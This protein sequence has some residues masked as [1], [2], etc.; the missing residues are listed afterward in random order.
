MAKEDALLEITPELLEAARAQAEE[1]KEMDVKRSWFT[2]AMRRVVLEEH[3][4]CKDYGYDSPEGRKDLKVL[5]YDSIGEKI[6]SWTTPEEE[7]M[8]AL[9]TYNYGER[10]LKAGKKLN[11]VDYTEVLVAKIILLSL[12]KRVDQRFGQE[13][14]AMFRRSEAQEQQSRVR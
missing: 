10:R 14:S 2:S 11:A 7:F 12:E 3:K 4:D 5:V 9:E 8:A 6:D 1:L 13:V